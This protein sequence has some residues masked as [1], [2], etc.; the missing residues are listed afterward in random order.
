M[1]N[2]ITDLKAK[3]R[4]EMLAEQRAQT[5]HWSEAELEP[6]AD[7]KIRFSL[8][9]I[10]REGTA[11]VDWPA[12]LRRISCPALLITGDPDRGGIITAESAAA[13]KDLVPQLQMAHIADAGHSIRRDQFDRYREAV[14][15]FLHTAAGGK[16]A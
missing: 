5:P 16:H 8:N 7:A 12:T 10:N 11:P 6:W 2:W 13:L 3:T 4:E 15:A 9:A 14:S 1:R